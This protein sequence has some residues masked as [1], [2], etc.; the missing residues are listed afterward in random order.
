MRFCLLP[1]RDVGR[2]LIDIGHENDADIS[3]DVIRRTGKRYVGSIGRGGARGVDLDERPAEAEVDGCPWSSTALLTSDARQWRRSTFWVK[4][5][6][7]RS[8]DS[9]WW[10]MW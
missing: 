3:Q 7:I 10:R 1:F 9:I 6:D 4:M 5:C 2:I 8:C